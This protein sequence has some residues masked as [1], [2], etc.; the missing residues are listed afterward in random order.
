[1]GVIGSYY[2]FVLI[3]CVLVAEFWVGAWPNGYKEMSGSAIATNFFE[4]YLSLP[5]LIVAYLGR[6]I[7]KKEWRIFIPSA[8]VD[9]DTGRREV[10]VEAMKGQIALEKEELS[11]KNIILRSYYFW[12]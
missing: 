4:T 9:I 11:K 7:Y 1:M 2:G 5:V 10:D 8:E 3:M 6:M 12:C